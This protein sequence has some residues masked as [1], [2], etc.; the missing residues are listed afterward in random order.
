MEF[1]RINVRL[2]SL[3]IFITR[4]RSTSHFWSDIEPSIFLLL[5]NSNMCVK[6][7]I[8]ESEKEI[9]PVLGRYSWW[10]RFWLL[11]SSTFVIPCDNIIDI[12]TLC[13]LTMLCDVSVYLLI[14]LSWNIFICSLRWVKW[15][16]LVLYSVPCHIL[17]LWFTNGMSSARSSLVLTH[18][19]LVTS[20]GIVELSTKP[21][22]KPM[23]ILS[24]FDL[25]AH[26]HGILFEIQ[27][28]WLKENIWILLSP[29]CQTF[30]HV[31]PAHQFTLHGY[32]CCRPYRHIIPSI[33]SC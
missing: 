25:Q 22:P 32:S 18:C 26:F 23:P 1:I 16:K 6:D 11:F 33:Q 31:A 20:Y 5:I 9:C 13:A 10:L 19:N 30:P 2:Y 29:K 24:P 4:Q 8:R 12:Y 15:K 17:R 28:L 3:R 14:Y 7:G 27:T 21:L